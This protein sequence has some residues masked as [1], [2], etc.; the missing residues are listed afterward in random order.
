MGW[1]NRKISK[2]FRS[3]RSER[4]VHFLIYKLGL[5]RGDINEQKVFKV[6][7]R[8]QEGGLIASFAKSK[9]WSREDCFH[10]LDGWFFNLRGEKIPFQIKSSFREA[11]KFVRKN[12]EIKVIVVEP[13]IGLDE[14]EKKMLEIF[15]EELFSYLY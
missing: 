1:H 11:E 3:R 5:R 14:L 6:L 12:P 15:N 2:Y 4:R 7:K 9:K 13:G 8:W 10:Q